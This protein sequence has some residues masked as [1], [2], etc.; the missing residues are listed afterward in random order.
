MGRGKGRGE[1]CRKL[2]KW[3]CRETKAWLKRWRGGGGDGDGG[4]GGGV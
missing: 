4:G 2:E 3:V 1:W